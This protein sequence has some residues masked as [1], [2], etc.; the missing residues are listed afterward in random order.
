MRRYK[1]AAEAEIGTRMS[2]WEYEPHWLRYTHDQKTRDELTR[3]NV[4]V[5]LINKLTTAKY[6]PDFWTEKGNYVEVKGRL[7]PQDAKKILLI[8]EQHNLRNNF[9]L[10]PIVSQNWKEKLRQLREKEQKPKKGTL[11]GA[12]LIE[13]CEN[14]DVEYIPWHSSG[15]NEQTILQFEAL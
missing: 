7:I 12:D 5:E 10:V 6:Y 14:H 9:Y 15:F 3:F 13:W 11:S 8:L 4:K 1:S 2:S